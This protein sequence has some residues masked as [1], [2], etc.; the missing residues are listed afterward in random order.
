[1]NQPRQQRSSVL[2]TLREL[3][4]NRPLYQSESLR[5]AELQAN[6]LLELLDIDEDRIST[7]IV[8]M[9][10]RIEVRNRHGMP[11]S[12]STYWENGRWIVAIN[13]DEPWARRR[14]S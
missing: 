3:V 9:L 14:F 4:P 7:S 5:I 12:G 2:A 1:M 6:R 8:A 11:V 10:P 13:A